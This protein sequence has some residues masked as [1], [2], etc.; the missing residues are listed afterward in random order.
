[1]AAFLLNTGDFPLTARTGIPII[2]APAGK[3]NP[4]ENVMIYI[5][6]LLTLYILLYT[7]IEAL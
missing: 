7:I 5:L 2:S 1:M 4:K 3:H 6:R